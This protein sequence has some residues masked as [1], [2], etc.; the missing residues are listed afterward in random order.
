M[1]QESIQNRTKQLY[2]LQWN[3]YRIVRSD[4]DQ[5]TIQLKTGL[6]PQDFS[7][8]LVLD[9]GCGMGRYARVAASWGATVLGMDLSLAAVAAQE[10]TEEFTDRV[11]IIR[12]DLL[13]IPIAEQK[14]DLVYS[15]G[16]L[17]HTP[18]PR[19]A[20]LNLARCVKP[21]GRMAIWV[22]QVQSPVVEKIM[23]LHR[24]FA[25]QLPVKLVE[26]L[27]RWSVPVG[28]LKRKLMLSQ[29][30]I[31]Q[32]MG[33]ALHAL[34][35]GV[36]MHPDPEVRAC[37]TLDWYAPRFVSHHT[38]EEVEEWFAQAGFITVFDP[39]A[40]A[41]FYHQG[42]GQGVHRVGIKPV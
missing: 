36:S 15:I 39:T 18:N 28:G 6:N 22:Y 33:V 27:S 34:T 12:G 11:Q 13:R 19:Q 25:R 40:E 24:A 32:R 20:F 29:W 23:K 16:V 5:A 35:I 30:R 21:G 3:R 9:G 42:Q 8:K 4:E 1:N 2:D 26:R 37:D 10:M 7:G 17:D 41:T 14:F 31:V 38:P